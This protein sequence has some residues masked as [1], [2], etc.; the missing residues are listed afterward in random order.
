MM[1]YY[2]ITGTSSGI[3]KALTIKLLSEPNNRVYGFGRTNVHQHPNYTHITKDFSDVNDMDFN[4]GIKDLNDIESIA[5]IN[6]AGVLDP[7]RYA[8]KLESEEIINA[9]NVNFLA[10]AILSNNFL[11]ETNHLEKNRVILN[12][13]SG[14]ASYPVDGW[15]LYCSTKS[16]LEMLSK[17]IVHET[18]LSKNENLFT[19]SIAP[20]I[21]ETNMQEQ[22]RATDSKDFSR[23]DEFRTL[24]KE[25]KLFDTTYVAE[26]LF[27]ILSKPETYRENIFRLS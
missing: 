3:G 8:G 22:I 7:I 15:M 25:N 24:K 26:K 18:N 13:S 5:L 10:P 20:G 21:V 23:V 11:K 12:I 9:V 17:V 27:D 4:F 16:A 1:N 14:A 6:N 19:F 2:Y